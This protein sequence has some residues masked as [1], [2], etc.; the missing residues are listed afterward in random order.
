MRKQ[1]AGKR[2]QE[3]NDRKIN[4]KLSPCQHCVMTFLINYFRS[5]RYPF[6][7][8]L[9]A[10]YYFV[11][12]SVSNLQLDVCL[13]GVRNDS[14]V[15]FRCCVKQREGGKTADLHNARNKSLWQHLYRKESF[16]FWRFCAGFNVTVKY[17]IRFERHRAP[18][19]F[20]NENWKSQ[21]GKKR[22][23]DPETNKSQINFKSEKFH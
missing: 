2:R 10:Q 9:I 18:W 3:K 6:L 23:K 20:A 8:P 15:L 21:N 22:A 14:Q 12:C 19:S 5:R 1:L 13:V 7:W 17:A 11:D 4:Q 16:Q